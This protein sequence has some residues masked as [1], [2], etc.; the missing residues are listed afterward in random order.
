MQTLES[1][2]QQ[3]AAR[4]RRDQLIV[5]HL[6]L[7][8]H[9]VG[10]MLAELPP[11]LDVEN[12]H[13]AATL[14]L[15]EAAGKFD[16]AHGVD[17]RSYA[18]PRVRGA[19]LDELRRNCPLPQEM[20]QRVAKVRA[21]HRSLTPPVSVEQ[22]IEATDLTYDEVVD[23]LAAMRMTRTVSW[24]ESVHSH[25]LRFDDPHGQPH[26]VLER[27]EQKQLLADAIERLPERERKV[28]T[29]YYLEELR[30]KEIGLVLKVSESRV[31]RLLS[32]A[33]FRLSE[34]MRAR[35]PA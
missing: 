6:P 13:S 28:V 4:S 23:S 31:S 16:P 12:L 27:A 26:S 3:V 25:I 5:E 22:L 34:R 11:G 24:E 33:L 9:V 20:M 19:V 2:Y 21:A 14:G 1:A 17:F 32:S 8:R 18:Y 35:E 15:V 7:V 29:L 30:L 10:R